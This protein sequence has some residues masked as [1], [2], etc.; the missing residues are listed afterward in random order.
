MKIT[1]N[2]QSKEFITKINLKEVVEQ[3]CQNSNRVIAEVN[4][5]IIRSHQWETL[6]L[7]DGDSIELVSFVGG[8]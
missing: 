8:G 4:G 5:D 6:S 2:G 1:L 7:N 3:F